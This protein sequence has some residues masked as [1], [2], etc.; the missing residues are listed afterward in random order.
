[1]TLTDGHNAGLHRRQPE[2]EGAGIVLHQHA[3]KALYRAEERAVDHQRL[4]A[5]A[6]FP[7]I[8]HL[9]TRRHVEVELY[10]RQLP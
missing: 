4:M 2:R 5:L 9:K 10:R 1:M 8:L 6:V 7:H 3:E